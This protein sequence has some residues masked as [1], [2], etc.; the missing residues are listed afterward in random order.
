MFS[1]NLR[2]KKSLKEEMKNTT[3]ITQ[4]KMCLFHFLPVCL[5]AGYGFVLTEMKPNHQNELQLRF[6]Q[7]C[8]TS[9]SHSVSKQ[10]LLNEVASE[11]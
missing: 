11:Q 7:K 2:K 5:S 6:S 8:S 10:H 3:T 4:L 9:T 1:E